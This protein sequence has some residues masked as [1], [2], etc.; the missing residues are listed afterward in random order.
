MAN[1]SPDTGE[2]L[3]RLAH[4]PFVYLTTIGRRSGEPHRIE[5]WFAVQDGVI[6]LM[7]GGRDRAD[8]V[9]NLQANPEVSFEL[10][11]E[12]FAGVAQVLL[13]DT[14]EDRRARELLVTKYREGN[15][16]EGWGRTSLPVMITIT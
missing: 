11:S 15:K 16:L 9:R 2:T 13:P 1:T 6:Y 10:G 3:A 4:Q 14:L 5:I 7:S 8:W 12:R